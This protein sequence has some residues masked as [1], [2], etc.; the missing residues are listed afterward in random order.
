MNATKNSTSEKWEKLFGMSTWKHF[1]PQQ[2]ENML[3]ML[4]YSDFNLR[5][6]R[7][8]IEMLIKKQFNRQEMLFLTDIFIHRDITR[9]LGEIMTDIVA[10]S[11]KE[12]GRESKRAVDGLLTPNPGGALPKQRRAGERRP[13]H[14]PPRP[15]G[16]QAL[17]HKSHSGLSAASRLLSAS[18]G[19]L[20]GDTW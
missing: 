4:S 8:L 17:S 13:L 6:W 19:P 20:P 12:K 3:F 10:C 18:F 16:G 9:P 7:T 11:L 15:T 1:T 5:Q 2:R 14:R